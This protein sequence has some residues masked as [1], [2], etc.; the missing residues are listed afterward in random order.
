MN[1]GKLIEKSYSRGKFVEIRGKF[2]KI[3]GKFVQNQAKLGLGILLSDGK[4]QTYR[5]C[6]FETEEGGV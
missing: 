6:H 3:C 5:Y 2:V 4:I 1:G